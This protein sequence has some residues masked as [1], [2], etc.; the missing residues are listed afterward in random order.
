MKR[1]SEVPKEELGG[2]RVLVRSS[3]NV[4][5]ENG[6]VVDP[7]RIKR[8]AE[9][10]SYLTKRGARVVVIGHIGRDHHE[11]LAPVARALKDFVPI[12]FVP[13]VFGPAASSLVANM[14]PGEAVLLENL[15]SMPE[16]TEND[17]TFA[18]RLAEYGDVFV[19]D[20]FAVLH[21]EHTSVVG[22]PQVLPSYAGLVVADEIKHLTVAL[23]PPSPAVC[24]LGGAKFET[25]VPLIEKFLRVYDTVCI[26]GALA[27][28]IY[29]ARGWEVGHSLVSDSV[30]GREVYTNARLSVAP[31]ATVESSTGRVRVADAATIQLDEKVVDIG[32]ET[33]RHWAPAIANAHFIIWNGP[34]GFYEGGYDEWTER[35]AQLVADSKAQTIVGGGDTIAAITSQELEEQFSF[36]STGGGAMLEFLLKGTLP[37]IEALN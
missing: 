13:E 5:L 37:G 2:T 33:L 28:D 10:I 19:Q 3:L 4:A 7:F 25:K 24:I 35:L 21:R 11:S 8:A 17:E 31:D 26:G 30:P 34:M 6:K 20:A 1:I 16:E 15:R 23:H 29:K 32:P 14:R 9:T 22:L 18:R 12:S 27:N 36:I